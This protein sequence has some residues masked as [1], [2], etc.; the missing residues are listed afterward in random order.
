MAH[1]SNH[2]DVCILCAL[3][4]EADA[5]EKAIKRQ[6]NV[7]FRQGFSGEDKY[8][9]H[10][11]TIQNKKKEALTL[12]L[13]WLPYKGL[14]ETAIHFKPILQEFRPRFA[15]MTGI[16]AGDKTKV[17]LG[18]LVIAECAYIYDGGKVILDKEDGGRKKYLSEGRID[19][20]DKRLI[21]YARRFRGWEQAA[22]H[23]ARPLKDQLLPQC[24]IAPLASGN[25][26]RSDSPFKEVQFPAY[27]TVAID[28]EG[29]AFYRVVSEFPG[30]RALLVKGVCDY[31]DQDKNDLYHEYAALLS[32]TYL[33]CFIREYVTEET[34]PIIPEHPSQ[35]RTGPS[36]VWNVPYRRNPVFTGRE[37]VLTLLHD[38]LTTMKA[39]AFTRPQA[40]NGLGGIGKTQIAIEYAYR[41]QGEYQAILWVNAATQD[42]LVADFVSLADLLNLSA[43][44]E[45]DQNL[46]INAVKRWLADHD[47]WLL[48]LDNVDRPALV[49]DFLPERCQGHSILTT[50][51]QAVGPI[52]QG[53]EVGE[54]DT[55]EGSK[56]LLRRAKILEPGGVLEQITPEDQIY[57]QKIV[58]A[59]GGLP[60]ALD[61]AGA[62]IEETGCSLTEY[63]ERFK[64]RKIAL[65]KRRGE[66]RR[67]H[68]D[69]VV[70][71]WSLSFEEIE[72]SDLAAADILRFCTFLAPDAIP[73]E[74]ITANAAELGA[75]FQPL[76]M[77]VSRFDEAIANL[78][79]FSLLGRN[80]NEQTLSIHRLVQIVLQANMDSTS[81]RLWAERVVRSMIKIF[82][83]IGEAAW[84]ECQRYLPHV[85]RCV[86]L[87]DEY[88]LTYLE[89][90]GLFYRT[91]RWLH[92]HAQYKEAEMFYLRALS[93]EEKQDRQIH[94]DLAR[95]L[96]SLAWLYLDQG[97]YQEAAP[98][99]Q[100]ALTIKQKLFGSEHPEVAITLHALGRLSHA[101]R[102]YGQAKT[103][104]QQ[105][106]AIK[107]QALG[108]DHVEAATTLHALAWLY[109][110]QQCYDQAEPLYQRA[111]SIRKHALGM[112]HASTAIT[113]HQLARLYHEQGRYPEAEPLYRQALTMKEQTLGPHHPFTAITLHYFARFYHD[114]QLYTQAEAHYQRALAIREQVLGP[115]HPF[116][117][118][119][120]HH[121]ARL[122]H[123][124]HLFTQ[125]E[126][127]YQRALVIREQV[128]GS[129]HFITAITLH[130]LARLREMQGQYVEAEHCYRRTLSIREQ[131]L[132]PTNPSTIDVAR[133][134]AHFLRT[135]QREREAAELGSRYSIQ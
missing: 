23:L 133:E 91:G 65:L 106:L 64:Q 88:A 17:H 84:R 49:Y 48:I 37:D 59:L 7:S 30:I 125:A 113:L 21:Q 127:H 6:Y 60:L 96:D 109:H 115:D 54:L 126:A 11:T 98:L 100:R 80:R 95:I 62:Y 66:M 77:D 135:L 61:Q 78:R 2:C 3:P 67:D 41:F 31:A 131:S 44:I 107:E 104:Y 120:L 13:S 32:A 15:A 130:H 10:S 87:V 70:A 124:Q 73:Q 129:D 42:T 89:V 76:A 20:P 39:A 82:P 24:H 83:T 45:V 79:R 114:Q 34:M 92:E 69:S 56:L 94:P 1:G 14:V 50:Q 90:V 55:E 93:L 134:Y 110:D 102:A 33:L 72:H 46:V 47:R 86:T 53:I 112:S 43:R 38:K 12:L 111:L 29:A 51:A 119:T 101:Q 35:S 75:H 118:T 74:L 81:Q 123:D 5:V 97:A 103:F 121:I 105:A 9:Y 108:S 85:Q 58:A 57:A 71:T 122:Y 28:M 99:Y 52:A 36:Y 8:E 27:K 117:A 116:T 16:C 40:I 22:K 132:G 4:E 63:L 19:N 68:P 18:D 26:V 128:Y 25:A